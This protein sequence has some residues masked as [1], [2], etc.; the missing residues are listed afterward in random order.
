MTCPLCKPPV[1]LGGGMMITNGGRCPKF[2]WGFRPEHAVRQPVV[3]PAAFGSE[4]VVG[5]VRLG[6]ALRGRWPRRGSGH[7]RWTGLPRRGAASSTHAGRSE[8]GSKHNRRSSN[9]IRGNRQRIS[10]QVSPKASCHWSRKSASSSAGMRGNDGTCPEWRPV[11]AADQSDRLPAWHPTRRNQRSDRAQA[12]PG[13]SAGPAPG[14][15]QPGG[16]PRAPVPGPGS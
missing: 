15:R 5:C 6:L 12:R 9:R 3:V 7:D 10:A 16:A 14:G 8:R 1:T 11:A 2:G 4:R 13:R